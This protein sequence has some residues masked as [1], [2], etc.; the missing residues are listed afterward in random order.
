MRERD[1]ALGSGTQGNNSTSSFLGY[2]LELLVRALQLQLFYIW[3]SALVNYIGSMPRHTC[4]H[5]W[6][7]F[8]H[9]LSR[10]R[11]NEILIKDIIPE[12]GQLKKINENK[13]VQT[14]GLCPFLFPLLIYNC[15]NDYS[16][17][18]RISCISP[19]FGNSG[20]KYILGCTLKTKG[21]NVFNEFHAMYVLYGWYIS[22]T[23]KRLN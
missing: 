8:L 7:G 21:V 19:F 6:R 13:T 12:G 1:S 4:S 5:S 3:D 17:R 16:W 22:K 11:M 15:S 9:Q 23:K 14:F 10:L 2:V 20:P 18:D